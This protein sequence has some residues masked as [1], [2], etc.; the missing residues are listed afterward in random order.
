MSRGVLPI[1]I[2]LAGAVV[3]ASLGNEFGWIGLVVG[4]GVG[5]AA[6]LP[7]ARRATLPV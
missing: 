5:F 4:L 1:A 6:S 7:I 2:M 3:G